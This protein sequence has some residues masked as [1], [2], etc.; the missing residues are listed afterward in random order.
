MTS[1]D[2]SKFAVIDCGSGKITTGEEAVPFF[3]REDGEEIS[4]KRQNELETFLKCLE[5]YPLKSVILRD[6]TLIF[7]DGGDEHSAWWLNRTTKKALWDFLL[8]KENHKVNGKIWC[9]GFLGSRWADTELNGRKCRLAFYT[10]KSDPNA[11]K[12]IPEKVIKGK[13]YVIMVCVNY[14]Y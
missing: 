10:K 8:D 1:T 2:T 12:G 9:N 4:N 5:T 13:D 7:Q 3:E 6:K 11:L 14:H